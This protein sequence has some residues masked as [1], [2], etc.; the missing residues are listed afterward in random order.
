MPPMYPPNHPPQVSVVIPVRNAEATLGA[1]LDSVL[2][3]TLGDLEVVVAEDGSTDG[4]A[5]VLAD[6]AARDPRVRPLYLPHRG[7]AHAFNAA[8]ASARAPLVARLDADDTCL[9]ERLR[10]QR[11]HLR[12][13]PHTGLVATRVEYGGCRA[14]CAGYAAHVDWTNGLLGHEE[15]RLARFIDLPFANPSVMFRRELVDRHGGARQ[16]DFPEDYEMWL[17]WYEGG[18]RMDKLPEALTVWNDPPDRATRTDPRY[19]QDAFYRVKAAF[20]ARWL[21]ASNA[22]HP[23]VVVMGAGRTSRKRAYMLLEHGVR[24]AAYVDIDPCKVGQVVHGVPVLSRA[25]MLGPQDCF[26]LAYVASRGARADIGAYLEGRG[27]VP[28]RHYIHVA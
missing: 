24:I 21:A 2:G 22:H 6:Y 23:D 19:S 9:P 28:G 5:R 15:M 16:G 18:V 7:V 27:F 13:H 12:D 3:Q 14:S 11:D 17:R 26:A 8:V 1:A 4:T 10:R 20:L 25:Q